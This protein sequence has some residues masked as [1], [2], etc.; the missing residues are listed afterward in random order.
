MMSFQHLFFAGLL[1][2]NADVFAQ[3]SGTPE[4]VIAGGGCIG[5]TVSVTVKPVPV[6]VEWKNSSGQ[7]LQTIQAALQ[8]DAITVAGRGS[9]GSGPAQLYGPD[10]IFVDKDGVV[11]VP[12]LQNNRVQKWLPGATQG[13]TVAGGN[14]AGAANNQLSRP[15][16]VFVDEQGNVFVSDQDNGRIQKWAPGATVGVTVA[17]RYL[18][19]P[20]D[21]L[22]YPTDVFVDNAGVIY[23]GDQRAGM[24]KKWPPGATG[25]TLVASGLSA[26]TGIFVTDNGD[27]YV[28]DTDNNRVLRF[29]PG[30][31]TATVVVPDR[32]YGSAQNQLSNP[33]DVHVDCQGNVF[34]ADYG[35]HRI[36]K[37]APGATTGA[38]VAGGNGRGLAANQLATPIGLVLDSA[39][40]IYVADYGNHRVQ[41]F[42]NQIKTDYK[43]VAPGKYAASVYFA[44]SAI[45][46]D[47]VDI[48]SMV[49]PTVA[50]KADTLKVCP[51]GSPVTFTAAITNG[52]TAPVY[53][54]MKNNQPAGTNAAEFK[55]NALLD[56]NEVYCVL[57]S[58]A[59]CATTTTVGSNKVTVT[60]HRFDP[61]SLGPDLII[62]PDGS[63]QL[64]TQQPYTSYRWHN[65]SAGAAVT[66]ANE[67]KYYVEVKDKCGTASS[68][69]VLLSHYTVAK[70][71]LRT[72]T[73]ICAYDTLLL[74]SAVAFESYRWSTGA[75]TPNVILRK[76]GKVKLTATDKN[77]CVTTDSV[78]LTTIQCPPKGIYMPSAFT[79]NGDGKNDVLKPVF[80]GV[81]SNYRFMVYNR[82]G[83]VE[84]ETSQLNK[85]WDGNIRGN[86]DNNMTYVWMC[87]YQL[88][89]GATQVARGTVVLLGRNH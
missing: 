82:N 57:E 1:L 80:Y 3:C 11:Y 53:K 21:Y 16:S 14:G 18:R 85:G 79:P 22:E 63:A 45:N 50:I 55:D 74:K 48:I 62:C 49:T 31:A 73:T 69:T 20:L 7:V 84:F 34:I 81:V 25:Y 9:A 67:G 19:G 5:T 13:I 64:K 10:R 89:G 46:T 44:G 83:Q 12:D 39:G 29:T 54:W 27:V 41:K 58:N 78:T 76:A 37:W 51:A 88:D 30:S 33:L 61:V 24:V 60:A 77:K 87:S 26:P 36:Q 6:S 17:G 72:D 8:K 71:F 15:T 68:D 86:R 66:V 70:D 56:N 4:A 47:S 75:V 65:G 35:N 59:A 52:G 38:T 28:C 32:G 23:V 2:L 43:P 40:N 42:E